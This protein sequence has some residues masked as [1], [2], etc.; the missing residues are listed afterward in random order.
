MYRTCDLIRPPFYQCDR[1]VHYYVIYLFIYVVRQKHVTVFSFITVNVHIRYERILM[2]PCHRHQST[3][4]PMSTPTL[5]TNHPFLSYVTLTLRANWGRMM[6]PWLPNSEP[7][8]NFFNLPQM[9][10]EARPKWGDAA[11]NM[12]QLKE[13]SVFILHQSH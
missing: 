5:P 3:P 13:D 10:G 4:P 7:G 12:T 11:H 1:K 9:D 2:R 8:G 6:G